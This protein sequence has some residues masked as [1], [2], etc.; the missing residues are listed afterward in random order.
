MRTALE[1][2]LPREQGLILQCITYDIITQF[3]PK[4]NISSFLWAFM[5]CKNM[6]L[7]K[8][9]HFNHQSLASFLCY[10]N[11]YDESMRLYEWTNHSKFSCS[12]I[13]KTDICA[14]T[15]MLTNV[16]NNWS[17]YIQPAVKLASAWGHC[18]MSINCQTLQPGAVAFHLGELLHSIYC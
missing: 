16:Y 10:N 9:K 6:L 17:M 5:H 2:H 3:N 8:D 14:C 4:E 13:L 11:F 15:H 18:E 12:T 1:C 7:F